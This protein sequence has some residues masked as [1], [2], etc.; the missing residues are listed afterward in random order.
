MIPI[1][2]L[3]LITEALKLINN[4]IEGVPVELRQAEALR[5][6]ATWWPL[7]KR[8]LKLIGVDDATI[9]EIEELAKVKR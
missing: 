1:A 5:F 4:L 8:L 2:V 9:A 6:F 7:N 3:A